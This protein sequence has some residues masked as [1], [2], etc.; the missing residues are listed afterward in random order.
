MIDLHTHTN[1]SDGTAGPAELLDAAGQTGLRALAI[2]D[3]DT[4]AGFDAAL[5]LAARSGVE[6]VCGIELST[7]FRSD[8]GGGARGPSMHV[9]GYFLRGIPGDEFRSWLVPIT[10]T[11]RNRNLELMEKLRASKIDISWEDF[12]DLGPERAAR[13]HFARA[14]VKKGCVPDLQSAFDLY[15]SDTVLAGIERKLPS[16]QEAVDRIRRHG[17]IASL[18]HPGRLRC[19]PSVLRSFVNELI[20]SG[21]DAIEACHSD[22]TPEETAAFLQIAGESGLL[23]TGGSDFHGENKPDIR[24]GS[25]RNGN[26][27]VPDEVLD[28]MKT[29]STTQSLH[30]GRTESNLKSRDGFRYFDL[31]SRSGS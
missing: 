11:R 29:H 25:G 19:R 4:L 28:S 31:I 14:L 12:P 7:Q 30:H 15:L 3:H 2:T 1:F 26:V 17:G 6:L 24:L 10:A 8:D 20:R 13:S 23:V 16:A 21:L 5:P 18:A 9:L 22:H 27:Q